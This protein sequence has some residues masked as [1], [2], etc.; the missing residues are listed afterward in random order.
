M[1]CLT[2]ITANLWCSAMYGTRDYELVKPILNKICK[3]PAEDIIVTSIGR[4]WYAEED[5]K[6]RYDYYP[7]W[8]LL[9]LIK[10]TLIYGDLRPYPTRAFGKTELQGLL[11]DIWDLEGAL[12]REIEISYRDRAWFLLVRRLSFQQRPFQQSIHLSRLA[13][14]SL[15]FGHLNA[16]DPLRESFRKAVGAQIEDFVELQ[17]ALLIRFFLQR[18]R[19]VSEGWFASLAKSYPPGT[20]ARL[21]NGLS[22]DFASARQYLSDSRSVHSPNLRY[23]L[24]EMSPLKRFPLFCRHGKYYCYSP[25]LLYRALEDQIYDTLRSHDPQAFG[26]YFGKSIFEDYVGRAAFH[27][28]LPVLTE[29][30]L[31]E[32]LGDDGKLID[33]LIVEGDVHVFIEAKAVEMTY[34]GEVTEDPDQITQRVES[35]V[36]KGI[37]Q[38]YEIAQRLE[39]V[40]CIGEIQLGQPL[41]RY[42]LIVTYKDLYLGSS[43][44]FYEFLAKKILDEML[45]EFDNVRWIPFENMY[46]VSTEDFELLMQA[47]HEGRTSIAS[48]LRHAVRSDNASS[49]GKK[50]L[51]LRQHLHDLLGQLHPPAYLDEEFDEIAK[52]VS[53]KFPM[54]KE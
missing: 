42:L 48:C 25:M 31:S 23:E 51:V 14:Q 26:N 53:S 2:S 46:F 7:V 47:V 45:T 50:K 39:G 27:S 22:L 10:W 3:Y 18:Q 4:I 8:R 33:Y 1:E 36:V 9:L 49:S 29:T 30:N 41:E 5:Y 44:D 35:S 34:I 43:G 32:G 28:G 52:R 13:R 38:A 15:L 12:E 54:E 20:V 11:K 17:L 19:E 37:R 6:R 21:L 24:S 16:D 40:E